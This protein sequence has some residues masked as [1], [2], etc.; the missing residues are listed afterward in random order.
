LS[1]W[2]SPLQAEEAKKLSRYITSQFEPDTVVSLSNL[3]TKTFQIQ[4]RSQQ[5]HFQQ[6]HIA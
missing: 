2:L 3:K 6:L 5:R 4:Q 1:S